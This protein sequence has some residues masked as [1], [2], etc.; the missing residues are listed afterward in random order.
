MKTA[1]CSI[2]T[3]SHLYKARALFKSLQGLSSADFRCLITDAETKTAAEGNV[4][5]DGLSVL[6]GELAQKMKKKYTGNALRWSCKPL[7]L[8][9]LL[10]QGY[11]KVIY[12]DNDIA[13][14]S[15]PH[16]LLDALNGSSVL[17]TPHHYSADTE[18]NTEWLEANFRVGL[19]NAG[20]VGVSK[21]ALPALEWWAKCCLY[22]IRQSAWRG[23][24]DDQKYLD[25]LPI[26]FDDVHIVKHKG[27]NVA[28]W[29]TEISFRRLDAQQNLVL[30]KLAEPLVF[31][32]FTPLTFKKIRDGE[33][34]LL[35][36]FL[37][38][39]VSYLQ[40]EN[41]SFSID[42]ELILKVKDYILFFRYIYWR[43]VRI[44]Q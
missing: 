4:R 31:I 34:A 42:K 13:F 8:T 15:S 36:P 30:G 9:Y 18:K 10:E 33:D 21:K 22:D 32:H 2:S 23:L 26:L 28:G 44:F 5:F 3:N 37:D 1:I 40:K 29:N 16:F 11:D 6:H 19:Y 24:F 35:K 20:F 41:D 12:V 39:Y 7:Y 38:T 17:L 14:F 43:F 27:C 25:L